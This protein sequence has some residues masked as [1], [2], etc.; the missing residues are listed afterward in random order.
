MIINKGE[1]FS[2]NS[3]SLIF[4]WMDIWVYINFASAN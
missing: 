1:L 2:Y 3:S 4:G